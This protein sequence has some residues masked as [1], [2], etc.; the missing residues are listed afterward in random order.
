MRAGVRPVL[1][2]SPG[3]LRQG[4]CQLSFIWM[5][6][7]VIK[8]S[9]PGLVTSCDDLALLLSPETLGRYP[10]GWPG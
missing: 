5:V 4:C 1:L 3:G 2:G 8:S 6:L 10:R 9:S 7:M